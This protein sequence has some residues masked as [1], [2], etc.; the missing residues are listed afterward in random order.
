MEEHD[1]IP[2]QLQNQFQTV[3]WHTLYLKAP[4]THVFDIRLEVGPGGYRADEP[5][6]QLVFEQ[7]RSQRALLKEHARMCFAATEDRVSDPGFQNISSMD[8]FQNICSAEVT[9]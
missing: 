7:Q 6:Q 8:S 1:I 4:T 3:Q 5:F 2:N 9:M